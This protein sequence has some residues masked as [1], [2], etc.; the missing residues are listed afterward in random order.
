MPQIAQDFDALST[1]SWVF[2]A[3]L[4]TQ[5]AGTPLWG[6]TADI[7]GRRNAL[8]VAIGTFVVGSIA[9]ALSTTFAQLAGFRAIQGVGGGG[10]MAVS[11]TLLAD[12]VPA[13]QRGAYLAPLNSM[14]AL[15]SVVG[16]VLGGFITDG[17][18]WRW[19]FWINVPIGAVCS[20]IL[21]FNVP[22]TIGREHMVI[23]KPA[24]GEAG[25]GAAGKAKAEEQHLDVGTVDWLGIFLVVASVTCLCLAVV[26]GGTTHPWGS[27]LIIALLVAAGVLAV[28][29]VYVE[30]W[31]AQDPVVPMRLFKSWNF[32]VCVIVGFFAGFAM[33][34]SYVY[35]PIFFQS[36]KGDSASQSGIH[37]IPMMLAMPIGAMMSG[38]GLTLLKKLDYKTYPIVGFVLTAIA[39]GLYSIM[40]PASPEYVLVGNLILG[41]I[42]GGLTIMVPL[43]VSQNSVPTAD[44]STAT[45]T[46]QFFQS[47][48]GLLNIAI[49]Q[50]Y[51]NQLVT[52]LTPAPMAEGAAAMAPFFPLAAN[53]T[54]AQGSTAWS[55]ELFGAAGAACAKGTAAAANCAALDAAKTALTFAYS[56]AVTHTFYISIAGALAGLIASFFIKFIPLSADNDTE[57][58]AAAKASPA[59]VAAV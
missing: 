47:I 43:L 12:I 10:L 27:P 5:T 17:P 31:V 46:M 45:S 13:S 36:A 24:E 20:L 57:N 23:R 28:A 34:G 2:L 9:C 8:L 37:M 7:L 14:F 38:A 16:P 39:S 49:M 42:A 11:L 54:S 18:G 25:E 32:S 50:S 30:G 40:T 22:H 44:V 56:T 26:W 6:R 58:A 53:F 41:G 59:P 52:E 3:F 15:A 55:T 19:C 33:F 48:A 1:I 35:L 4:L 21:W 29:L 51:F